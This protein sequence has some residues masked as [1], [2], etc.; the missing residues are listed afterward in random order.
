MIMRADISPRL[1]PE[2]QGRV[3]ENLGIVG[4]V[5]RRLGIGRRDW[6]TA[7]S[8]GYWG[9]C[10]AAVRDDGR[11]RFSTYAYQM[12][13][14][15]ILNGLNRRS[16]EMR[17]GCARFDERVY[18]REATADE[19]AP[20]NPAQLSSMLEGLPPRDLDILWRHSQGEQL[21]EIGASYAVSRERARQVYE[22]ARA[23]VLAN[24]GMGATA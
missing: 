9:L 5:M 12:I 20:P 17:K 3:L 19:S 13:R 24:C 23:K 16:V 8:D 1:T 2:Q 11:G 10:R 14:G 15:E 18:C 4:F 6:D 7:K 22:R 21:K